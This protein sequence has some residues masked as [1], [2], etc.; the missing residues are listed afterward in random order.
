MHPMI[1]KNGLLAASAALA[2]AL[3]TPAADA[4]TFVV[5]DTSDAK[6]ADCG[7][8]GSCTLRRA[9]ES[10]VALPGRD[11]ITFD[12]AVFRPG[13]PGTIRVESPLPIVADPA[14]TAIDGTGAGVRISSNIEPVGDDALAPNGLVFASAPGA[15]LRDVAVT[16]L[17]VSGFEGSGIVV[18]G[19]SYPECD[20]DVVAPVLRRVIAQWNTAVGISILG[21][22]VTTARIEESVAA[23]NDIGMLVNGL[24]TVGGARITRSAVKGNEFAGIWVGPLTGRVAD[25]AITDTSASHGVAPLIVAAF[26]AANKVALANVA[27]SESQNIG[28]LVNAITL[29]ALSVTNVV[30]SRNGNDGLFVGAD[31]LDGL[32][33]KDVVTNA[34]EYGIRLQ[35]DEVVGAKITQVTAAGNSANGITLPNL[36]GAKISRIAAVGNGVQGLVVGGSGNVLKQV[37]VAENIG[38]GIRLAGAGGANTIADVSATAN[39]GA[40]IYI[41]A[42]NV[43]NT[44]KKNVA[45][46]SDSIDVFD[47]NPGC[48]A[49]VWKS[50]VFERRNDPCIR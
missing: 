11:V 13:A 15:S 16:N 40:G 6:V 19:G 26:G 34:N 43:G 24:G 50:N 41:G 1:S 7:A 5:D 14:G 44:I 21:R 8:P 4:R 37:R 20:Q 49:N 12:P 47:A 28:I 10:A 33:L 18:C 42:A 23:D 31:S 9:I 17:G 25:L 29:S 36:K 3:W 35:V 48:G 30:S 27:V 32:V 46:G 45:L 38:D 39:Q 22:D 2:A